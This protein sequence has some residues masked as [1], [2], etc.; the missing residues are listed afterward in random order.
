[1]ITVASNTS[2]APGL[3]NTKSKNS[4]KPV[5]WP[6]CTQIVVS[7]KVFVTYLFKFVKNYY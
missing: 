5:Q 1:M 3:I 6:C 7:H 4:K 2:V